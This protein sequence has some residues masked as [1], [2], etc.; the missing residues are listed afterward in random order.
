[1]DKPL[2]FSYF[3]LFSFL[4]SVYGVVQFFI[5]DNIS[6]LWH[7]QSTHACVLYMY[8]QIIV[9]KGACSCACMLYTL[10]PS[11]GWSVN[12]NQVNIWGVTWF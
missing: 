4:T 11:R 2:V 12:G 6:I 1:M 3:V 10:C 5:G 9:I 8:I 7:L